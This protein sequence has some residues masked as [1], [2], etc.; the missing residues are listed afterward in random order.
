MADAAAFK[1]AD[2]ENALPIGPRARGSAASLTR[3]GAAARTVAPCCVCWGCSCCHTSTDKMC[4]FAPMMHPI[5]VMSMDP[6][7]VTNTID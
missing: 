6:I 5:T 3:A 7:A 4:N 2:G 1:M